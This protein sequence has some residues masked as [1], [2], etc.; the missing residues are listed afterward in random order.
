M[1]HFNLSFIGRVPLVQ[2]AQYVPEKQRFLG[3]GFDQQHP[4]I[5][6]VT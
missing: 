2:L 4:Q 1:G 5:H 3:L 6:D